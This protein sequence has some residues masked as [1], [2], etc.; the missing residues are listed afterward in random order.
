MKEQYRIVGEGFVRKRKDGSW[1][2]RYTIENINTGVKK[3]KSFYGKL[4]RDV[5]AKM[6]AYAD[7]LS[8]P[9]ETKAGDKVTLGEWMD[10]WLDTYKATSIRAGTREKYRLIIA[11][12]IKPGLGNTDIRT[13]DDEDIQAFLNAQSTAL[14]GKQINEVRAV[15]SAALDKARDKGYIPYNP[16]KSTSRAYEEHHKIKAMTQAEQAAFLKAAEGTRYYLLFKLALSTGM[17][18]GELMGLRWEDIDLDGNVIRVQEAV[19]KIGT[20]LVVGEVKSQSGVRDIPIP[21]ALLP[22]LR[23][24]MGSGLIFQYSTGTPV[25]P[26][27]ILRSMKTICDKAGIP[28]YNIKDLR[29]TF[30]TRAAE[31][32]VNPKILMTIMGHSKVEVTLRYYTSATYE[33]KQQAMDAV[34]STT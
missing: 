21:A 22:V 17:R 16:A 26:S 1:E 3:P 23:D 12:K 18:R 2:G 30:A 33:M 6:T 20:A 19:T 14:A 29:S 28:Q 11:N 9:Q 10:T 13:L 8:G 24:S 27:Y 31:R 5:Q 7:T 25:N 15:L 4:R 32:G 34:F